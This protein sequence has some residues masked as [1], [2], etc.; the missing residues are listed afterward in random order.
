MENTNSKIVKNDTGPKKIHFIGIA[1]V[2]SSALACALHKAGYKVTGSD[3]GFFPPAST[4]LENLGVPFYAGWHPEKMVEGGAPD[5]VVVATASGSQNPE[6]LYAKEHGLNVCSYTDIIRDYIVAENSIVVS[7]TWG[8]TTSSTLLTY[9]LEQAGKNPSYMFGGISLMHE[10]SAKILPEKEKINVNEGGTG[11]SHWSVLEGDEYKS[12]P[13]D[14]TP[15]FFYYNP[16]HLLLTAVSWDHAD[17]Y[18]TENSYFAVF[19]K[20]IKD[21]VKRIEEKNGNAQN[22]NL[23]GGL[24][25]LCKDHHGLMNI[26]NKCPE[27][28]KYAVFYGK[29]DPENTNQN[30]AQPLYTYSNINQNT[31][32]LTFNITYKES[33]G[34]LKVIEVKSPMLGAYN[35]EN[36]TGCFAVAHSIGIPADKVMQAISTFKGM[37]RRLQKRFEGENSGAGENITVIDDIAHSAEKATAVLGSLKEIYDYVI[38]VF[39]PNSGGRARESQ[40]KYDNAFKSADEV[41]IP[42]LTKLKIAD[43]TEQAKQTTMPMDGAELAQV[44]AKT[45]ANTKYIESDEALVKNLIETAKEKAKPKAGEK[46][47]AN[48]DSA[49]KKVVIA[50]LGSHGFRNMIEEVVEVMEK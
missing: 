28:L 33:T 44:I 32:G 9:I 18:P 45:H 42:R 20:L 40:G 3:K 35:V 43:G 34:D 11:K 37:K 19:E 12:G 14:P 30:V 4:Q 46:T 39:E 6:T 49:G 1:G 27:V 36:I 47:N 21:T 26:V 50:F 5:I 13:N 31:D 41:I 38:A 25:A 23:A 16:T 8:K 48:A 22:V 29:S 7:G 17:L 10:S 2:L 24:I 15:K